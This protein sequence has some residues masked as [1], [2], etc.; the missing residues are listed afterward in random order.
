[1]ADVNS[2]ISAGVDPNI[3]Q[4]LRS[5]ENYKCLYSRLQPGEPLLPTAVSVIKTH[6]AQL[7]LAVDFVVKINRAVSFSYLDLTTLY[8]RRQVCE[9]ELELNQPVLPDIYLCV[10]AIVALND[11]SLKFAFNSDAIPQ[12]EIVREW[13]LIMRRFDESCVL[14]N[15]AR[16]GEFNLELARMTGQSIAEYHNLLPTVAGKDGDTRIEE[17][18]AELEFELKRLDF[19][20]PQNTIDRLIEKMHQRFTDLKERLK[21]RSDNGCIRRCHGDLH[22]R[23]IMIWQL[24][25]VPFDALEIDEM[26][27]TTDILYDLAFLIMDLCYRDLVPAANGVLNEYFLRTDERNVSDV[28]LLNLFISIRA[29]FRA[30]TTAQGIS[31]V[32]GNNVR[33]HM[34]NAQIEALSYF[35]LAETALIPKRAM[36]VA[37]G[38][39]SGSGKSTIARELCTRLTSLPGA[40][41][42]QPDAERKAEFSIYNTNRLAPEHYTVSIADSVNQRVLNRETCAIDSHYPVIVDATFLSPDKR[43]DI[44]ALAADAQ[45]DFHGFWLS[46]PGDIL[47]NRIRTRHGDASDTNLV[48]L[49]KQ[50]VQNSGAISW[51]Y[52]N[53]DAPVRQIVEDITEHITHTN[54]ASLF[55][56]ESAENV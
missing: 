25:P 21:R 9:R 24:K 7:Y 29:A 31:A 40:V 23:N 19:V 49:E 27:A 55:N 6:Y 38:G 2:R 5:R 16:R 39:L 52:T 14:D 13:C 44:A 22:L 18:I 30:I 17:I 35:R 46:A 10:A 28:A 43:H 37:I 51:K 12:D 26:L 42:L 50:L 54:P 33:A 11:G 3:D 56:T 53:S 20:F 1:M 47:K 15:V 41:L 48:E 36:V 4:F 32:R 8:K 34:L 45:V